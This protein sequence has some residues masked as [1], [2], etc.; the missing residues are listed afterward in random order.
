MHAISGTGEGCSARNTFQT[1]ETRESIRTAPSGDEAS[2]SIRGAF[3]TCSLKVEAVRWVSEGVVIDVKRERAANGTNR[4]V[5]LRPRLLD[6]SKNYAR[7]E[8]GQ[9][10]S[11]VDPNECEDSF[12]S[13][14]LVDS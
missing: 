4:R 11:E 6:Q 8:A 2:S 1:S 13:I 5:S 10:P 12:E 14:A 9:G 3:H 7:D